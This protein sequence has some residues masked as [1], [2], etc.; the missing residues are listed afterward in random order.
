M[1]CHKLYIIGGCVPAEE[2]QEPPPQPK[3]QEQE[4]KGVNLKSYLLWISSLGIEL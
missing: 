2:E 4:V 3:E 1:F